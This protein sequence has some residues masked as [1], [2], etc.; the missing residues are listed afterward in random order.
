MKYRELSEVLT[1]LNCSSVTSGERQRISRID[2]ILRTEYARGLIAAAAG[3]D[4]SPALHA[5]TLA[6]LAAAT[7]LGKR[8]FAEYFLTRVKGDYSLRQ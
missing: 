5:F 6:E 7:F 4:T 3:L 8:G 2:V 1:R